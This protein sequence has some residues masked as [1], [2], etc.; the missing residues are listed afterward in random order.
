MPPT[1]RAFP[2]AL[3]VLLVARIAVA[4][5]EPKF[6]F[7][8][9]D[10]AKPAAAKPAVEWKAQVKGGLL[11]TSGNSQTTN[12]AL[13][14]V[15]SRKQDGN[16]LSLEGGLAYGKSNI[17]TAVPSPTDANMITGISRQS[18]VTTNNWRALGRYDRFFTTNNSGY[19]S[20][21]AGAD[22]IAGKTFAGGGQAGYSRQLV[23]TGRNL[24]V[25][26]LGYDF[27]YESYVQ[28]PMKTLDAVTIH[29]ARIFVGETLKLTPETGATASVESFLNLNTEGKALNVN[30]GMAGV[31]PLHDTRIIGK[32]GFS[33]TLRKSLSAAVGFT[34]RYDQNPAPLPLPSGTPATAS[35]AMGV[36]PFGEKIDTITEVTLIYTF[37]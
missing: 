24:L 10:E 8:K 35:Y 32:V 20:G 31:D 15:A 14:V 29:S 6:T 19:A 30:T 28:Q 3:G 27:S 36:Q 13:G 11:V 21:L 25:A 17:L 9:A 22:K 1:L 37:L 18:V 4:Q 7:V 33:T 23:N 34:L 12:G 2:F 16:K 5:S 26:E